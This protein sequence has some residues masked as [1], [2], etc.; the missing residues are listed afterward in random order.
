MIG[1]RGPF[2]PGGAGEA[3]P[4]KTVSKGGFAVPAEAAPDTAA[5]AMVAATGGLEAMLALQEM[6]GEPIADRDARRHGR[7]IL[8]EL[9]AL[10]RALLDPEGASEE[11]LARLA[12]LAESAPEAGDPALRAAVAGVVLRAK[13]EL[14]RHK[15]SA[16]V[17]PRAD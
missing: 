10:Q 12:T 2:G 7:A 1:I 9:A 6:G 8:D 15:I 5:P 4:R 3:A 14:A 11:A 16:R 17:M 13:V